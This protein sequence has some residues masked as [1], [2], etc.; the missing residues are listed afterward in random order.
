MISESVLHVITQSDN[1]STMKWSLD[2][3][4][5]PAFMHSNKPQKWSDEDERCERTPKC[6]MILC[7]MVPATMR[8]IDTYI[9]DSLEIS[10]HRL[11][12]HHSSQLEALVLTYII[13][14]CI[15]TFPIHSSCSYVCF[16]YVLMLCHSKFSSGGVYK[17][18]RG[19]NNP[20][21]LLWLIKEI[22][23]DTTYTHLVNHWHH[24]QPSIMALSCLETQ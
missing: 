6:S 17:S 9:L 12:S 2:L 4:Y 13:I 19:Y 11:D 14:I 3:G 24:P 18:A 21:D 1:R 7:W 8:A 10:V 5:F 15:A 23:W 20:A 22:P 16:V